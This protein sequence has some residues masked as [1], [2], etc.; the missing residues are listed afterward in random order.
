M[1]GMPTGQFTCSTGAWWKRAS[2]CRRRL[3]D[4]MPLA[5]SDLWFV[6]RQLAAKP[7]FTAVAV[8]SLALGIGANTA[9]F[10]VVEGTLVR[11]LPYPHADRLLFLN[12]QQPAFGD[13]S[14]SPG[15]YLEYR[16]Q[17]KSFSDIAAIAWQNLT[18]T[19]VPVPQSL[20]GRAVSSNFFEVLGAQAERGRLLSA[21]IDKPN[22]DAR[23]AVISDG[24]WRSTFGSDPHIVGRLITLNSKPFQIAGVLMSGQ[25]YPSDI[26]IWVA[27]RTVVPEYLEMGSPIKDISENFGTHWMLGVGR[28]KAGVSA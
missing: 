8:L 1:R 16:R 2:R 24:L 10:S 14:I 19:G 23:A 13:A 25:E 3:A 5:G 21:A 28:L 22:A 11:P 20:H 7:F 15:E 12:D 26:Q 4:G 17:S 27:P 6:L 9:I 18:L